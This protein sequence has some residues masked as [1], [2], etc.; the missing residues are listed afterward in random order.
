MTWETRDARGNPAPVQAAS[1]A[2]VNSAA[3]QMSSPMRAIV[4]DDSS[5]IRTILRRMLEC[6]RFQVLEASNGQEA[7]AA[8]RDN[9]VADLALIDWNMP[10]MNGF[11]LLRQIK[12]EATYD[13]MRLMMVTTE[14]EMENVMQALEAGANEYLMKPFTM[15]QVRDKLNLM[16]FEGL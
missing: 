16:G 3:M 14:T 7:L 5:V 15:E 13:G 4:V 9:G 1:T 2:A 8:L 11:E 10:V 12:K 6:L